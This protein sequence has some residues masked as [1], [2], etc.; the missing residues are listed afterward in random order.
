MSIY[1]WL[2]PRGPSGYGYGSTAEQVTAGL[3]LTGKAFLVTGCTSGLG[4]EAVRVLAL[5]GA[6]VLGTARTLEKAHKS[7]GAV[8][9]A[10]GLC[11]RR[12]DGSVRGHASRASGGLGQVS[13]RLQCRAVE[14]HLQ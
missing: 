10:T 5:R 3:D 6:R 9:G 1:R 12:G 8:V 2:A 13:C 11:C 4:A 14:P 7:C